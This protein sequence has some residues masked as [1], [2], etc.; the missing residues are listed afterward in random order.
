MALLVLDDFACFKETKASLQ[1]SN[2][3]ASSLCACLKKF[4]KCGCHAWRFEESSCN[5]WN[6]YYVMNWVVTFQ[7]LT[8]CVLA[9]N[10]NAGW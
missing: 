3:F 9:N 7:V 6:Y 5:W 1:K 4:S 2:V 10:K 8:F